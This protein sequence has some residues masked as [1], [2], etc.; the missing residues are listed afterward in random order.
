M[1]PVLEAPS[2]L[3]L[4]SQGLRDTRENYSQDIRFTLVTKEGSVPELQKKPAS[5]WESLTCPDL[6]ATTVGSPLVVV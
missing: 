2:I 4:V 3:P 6:E 5:A 1:W